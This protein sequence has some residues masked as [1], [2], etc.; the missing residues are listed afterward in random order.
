MI[1]LQDSRDN[2]IHKVDADKP[3]TIFSCGYTPRELI[4]LGNT[5]PFYLADMLRRIAEQDDADVT[6]VQ[7]TSD[8]DVRVDKAAVAARLPRAEFVAERIEQFNVDSAA[9]GIGQANKTPIASA[10]IGNVIAVIQQLVNRGLTREDDQSVSISIPEALHHTDLA[11]LD[12]EGTIRSM[13]CFTG[14]HWDYRQ[15]LLL[16]DKTATPGWDS[17]WGPGRPDENIPCVAVAQTYLGAPMTIHVGSI[18]TYPHHEIEMAVGSLASGADYAATWIHS[19]VVEA[20][21]RRMANSAGN[22]CTVRDAVTRHGAAAVRMLY[23]GTSYR[24]TLDASSRALEHAERRANHLRAR[25]IS[26]P[27]IYPESTVFKDEFHAVL[28]DDLGTVNALTLL[29]HALQQ[30]LSRA[31]AQYARNVLGLKQTNPLKSPKNQDTI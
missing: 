2:G 18:D 28:R 9:I 22:V 16:W 1:R 5:R 3:V 19:G 20:N 24:D 27:E 4:H 7:G 15:E 30:G 25:I 26:A 17:P 6:L 29:E 31:D 10:H 23:L 21:G 14:Q 8:I 11:H 13:M 12:P